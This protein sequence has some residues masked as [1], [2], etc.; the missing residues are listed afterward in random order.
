MALLQERE[1]TRDAEKP[2]LRIWY[3]LPGSHVPVVKQEDGAQWSVITDH[4][5]TPTELYHETG[6]L[7][8]R[9]RLN[10]YGEPEVLVGRE[11]DCL[12]RFQGQM[13]DPDVGEVYNHHRWYDAHLGQYTSP[14]PIGL[15]GGLRAYGYVDD[16]NAW[17]DP[18]GL[19]AE[20]CGD[21]ASRRV[22]HAGDATVPSE[23][24]ARRRAMRENGM[25]TSQANNFVRETVHG[26][27]PNLKG[28]KGEPTEQIVGKDLH[29]REV[30]IDHHKNGHHF[31]DNNTFELPHYHGKSGHI[32]YGG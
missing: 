3:S 30:R 20:I 18:W 22:Q 28:L 2:K 11:K 13:F 25:S 6:Y 15:H 16:P 31:D 14:D 21:G 29:G 32:S 10:S 23:R 9:Q 26:K 12:I 19:A 1:Q 4:L 27:N 5:G 17:V 24:A 7:A 8:W